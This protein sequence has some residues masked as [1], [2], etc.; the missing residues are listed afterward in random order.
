MILVLHKTGHDWSSTWVGTPVDAVHFLRR[1]RQETPGVPAMMIDPETLYTHGFVPT[2]M[3][4]PG[5]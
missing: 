1:L 2:P 3:V 5:L 4:R